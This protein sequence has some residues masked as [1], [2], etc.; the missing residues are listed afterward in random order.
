M[1][2]QQ[3]LAIVERLKEHY[4]AWDA[5]AK[6]FVTEAKFR[7]T[8]YT[9]LITTLL[10]LRTQDSVTL[11][12][13]NRL[14]AIADTPQEMVHVS[15]ETIER[16]IYPVGMYRRKAATILEVSQALLER[17]GGEV[18]RSLEEL[19]SIKGVGR[20]TA[21]IVLESGYGLPYM[22]V[23]THVHRILNRWGFVQT[24]SA[25]ETDRV[26]EERLPTELRRGLNRLLVSFGQLYCKPVRPDCRECP[27]RETLEEMG[28][29]CNIADH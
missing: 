2:L 15:R 18:P 11:Q 12:A 28:I 7:R 21:K 29:R 13:A 26:L 6:R 16:A 19:C 9:I 20:K 4:P 1:T 27:V 23:D 14:F 22:A 25:Q 3:F 17:F 5:P 8:P 24:K 10:S